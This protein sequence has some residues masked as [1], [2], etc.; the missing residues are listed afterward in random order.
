MVSSVAPRNNAIS[1]DF[2]RT[3]HVINRDTIMAVRILWVNTSLALASSFSP[4][5]M[6][7]MV[8]E[9]TENNNATE[10]R[11]VTN[12]MAILTPDKASSDTPLATN[13]PSIIV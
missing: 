13:M 3:I 4:N 6:A 1:S 7:M 10:K 9:P 5:S 12:G 8:E 2:H 11:K